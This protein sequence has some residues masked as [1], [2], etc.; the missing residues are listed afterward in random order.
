M[1]AKKSQPTDVNL[2]R[3]TPLEPGDPVPADAVTQQG[4]TFAER[5]KAAKQVRSGDAEDKAVSSASTKKRAARKS[6]KG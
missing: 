4:S 6:A 1:A 3:A 5:A 2:E